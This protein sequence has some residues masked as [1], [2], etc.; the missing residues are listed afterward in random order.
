MGETRGFIAQR[1]PHRA[2]RSARLNARAV[3][4]VRRLEFNGL[5]DGRMAPD[6]LWEALTNA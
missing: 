4:L 5:P 6:E 1:S 2:G 3:E